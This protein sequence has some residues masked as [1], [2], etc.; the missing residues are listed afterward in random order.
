MCCYRNNEYFPAN[1]KP[2]V[3][4]IYHN[5]QA[6]YIKLILH[7]V[8]VAR[9]M[10]NG[11][12]EVESEIF[13]RVTAIDQWEFRLTTNHVLTPK[14]RK[15]FDTHTVPRTMIP[16]LSLRT[17]LT[18]QTLQTQSHDFRHSHVTTWSNVIGCADEMKVV[19]GVSPKP[20]YESSRA[21]EA[22]LQ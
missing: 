9:V 14:T 21:L 19:I 8:L 12:S 22:R 5:K 2:H 3:S 17:T 20:W 11:N 6:P 7:S 10:E 1:K 15:H 18:E 4:M 16:T 13:P